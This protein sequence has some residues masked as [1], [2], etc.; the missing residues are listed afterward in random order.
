MAAE[1][2]SSASS[3]GRAS[4]GNVASD[5]ADAPV[6]LGYFR[7]TSPEADAVLVRD[8]DGAVENDIVKVVTRK[9]RR[10]RGLR[11]G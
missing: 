1:V 8:A 5:E 2:A 11:W 3:E 7:F 10:G 9:S 4:W 6:L